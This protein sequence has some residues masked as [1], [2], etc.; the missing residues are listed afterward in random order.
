MKSL[1]F[2]FCIL[3]EIASAKTALL[4]PAKSPWIALV[5]YSS[6]YHNHN[7]YSG[8]PTVDLGISVGLLGVGAKYQYDIGGG[9]SLMPGVT[10][11]HIVGSEA[12]LQPDY[13]F[14]QFAADG[15]FTK[16]NHSVFAGVNTQYT[17][18][19]S[20]LTYYP[21]PGVEVGYFYE[22]ENKTLVEIA[23]NLLVFSSEN[24]AANITEQSTEMRAF[25]LAYELRF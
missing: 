7:T 17:T 5:R 12:S 16:N 19:S 18:F 24:A 23:F 3:S 9:F 25:V 10:Y 11:N 21:V 4:E 2:F 1:I 15:V 6:I 8:G 14:L 13:S 22:F 20:A